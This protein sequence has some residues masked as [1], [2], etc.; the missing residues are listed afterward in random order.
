M[1]RTFYGQTMEEILEQ[2]QWLVACGGKIVMCGCDDDGQM[3]VTLE[4]LKENL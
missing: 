4:V 1:T 2:A 3:Y